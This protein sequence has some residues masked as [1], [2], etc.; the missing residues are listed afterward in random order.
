MSEIKTPILTLNPSSMAQD[1]AVLEEAAA[2]LSTPAPSAVPAAE[3]ASEAVQE[4][5]T[6]MLTAEEKQAI[7][8]IIDYYEKKGVLH[9]IN[10]A[11]S[12]DEVAEEVDRVISND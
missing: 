12:I 3:A 11:S 10:G 6:S 8:P 4:M 1:K 2:Q 9:K 7:E 5:D